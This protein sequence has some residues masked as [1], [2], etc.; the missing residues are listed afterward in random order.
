VSFFGSSEFGSEN[1]KP[2]TKWTVEQARTRVARAYMMMIT[3]SAV[4]DI[5]GFSFAQPA[6]GRQPPLEPTETVG[7][8]ARHVTV[9]VDRIGGAW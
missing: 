7:H 1:E 2:P 6:P 5:G 3:R 4:K 8:A 9:T